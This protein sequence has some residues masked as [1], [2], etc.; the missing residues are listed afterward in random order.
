VNDDLWQA[1]DNARECG[2]SYDHVQEI[3]AVLEGS[4]VEDWYW[5]ARDTNGRYLIVQ[6]DSEYS[7]WDAG[8]YVTVTEF[9]TLSDC[10]ENLPSGT[11]HQYDAATNE[12]QIVDRATELRR[13]LR[14]GRAQTLRE[15]IN[16]YVEKYEDNK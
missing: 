11:H 8:S 14:E 15:Q 9:A 4:D 3:L 10:T 2:L 13:Q 16:E 6:G 12:F 1:L 7:G 5:V